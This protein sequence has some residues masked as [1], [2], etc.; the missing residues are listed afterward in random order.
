MY[1]FTIHHNVF[2]LLI[3]EIYTTQ[4]KIQANYH[5]IATNCTKV[6]IENHLVEKSACQQLGKMT[7]IQSFGGI[8]LHALYHLGQSTSKKSFCGIT[9]HVYHQLAQSTDIQFFCA[10]S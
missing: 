9:L 2:I 6:K 5:R 3:V 4:E 10:C 8:T 1:K 7:D